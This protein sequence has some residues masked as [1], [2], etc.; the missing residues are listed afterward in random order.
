MATPTLHPTWKHVDGLQPLGVRERAA[1]YAHA[2][3]RPPDASAHQHGAERCKLAEVRVRCSDC[4]AAPSMAMAAPPA[5]LLYPGD[6]IQGTVVFSNTQG[7]RV[8]LSSGEQPEPESLIGY[9]TPVAES[10]NVCTRLRGQF[11]MCLL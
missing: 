1:L 10:I 2:L 9:G 6:V 7:A 4:Y 3:R 8:Q 5:P 11:L